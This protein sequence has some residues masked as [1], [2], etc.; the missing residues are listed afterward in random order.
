ME[1]FLEVVV[2]VWAALALT[3]SGWTIYDAVRGWF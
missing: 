2:W 3:I 1:T